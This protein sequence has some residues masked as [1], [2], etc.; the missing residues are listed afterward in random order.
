MLDDP[1]EVQDMVN[2]LSELNP[3]SSSRYRY[4]LPK[5]LAYQQQWR[6]KNPKAD[7]AT[8]DRYYTKQKPKHYQLHENINEDLGY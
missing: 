7:K 3:E 2:R 5:L 8:K 4:N 1:G 6:L